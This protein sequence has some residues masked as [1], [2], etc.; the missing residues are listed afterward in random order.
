M[1]STSGASGRCG[2]FAGFITG[3]TYYVQR[4]FRNTRD[5]LYFTAQA[6]RCSSPRAGG[7]GE[8]RAPSYSSPCL[9]RLAFATILRNVWGLEVGEWLNDIGAVT[10]LAR[11]AR[12]MALGPGHQGGRRVPGYGRCLPQRASAGVDAQG[13]ALLVD[14]GLCPGQG[15]KRPRSWAVRNS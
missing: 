1:A 9:L 7:T 14:D 2:P 10:R 15:R 3:W 12:L 8:L 13:R 5:L 11:R 6:T 4:T